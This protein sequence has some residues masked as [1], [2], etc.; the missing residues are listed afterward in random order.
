[1]WN[2]RSWV[3]PGTIPCWFWTKRSRNGHHLFS[4]LSFFEIS[5]RP[6]LQCYSIGT[7][8]TLLVGSICIPLDAFL[9]ASTWRLIM[10]ISLLRVDT[11]SR[12]FSPGFKNLIALTCCSLPW[13]ELFCSFVYF[14][15]FSSV[16]SS[17]FGCEEH[18]S[19]GRNGGKSVW[20][21]PFAGYLHRQCVREEDR[22]KN[23]CSFVSNS[24]SVFTSSDS[25]QTWNL[26]GIETCTSSE[27]G[28]HEISSVLQHVLLVKKANMKSVWY[29]NML[30]SVYFHCN[31]VSSAL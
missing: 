27:E 15:F 24:M 8:C 7:V 9:P 18:S 1:M 16:R 3:P 11:S 13:I 4:R 19:R 6:F 31:R 21:W 23:I 26:F 20:F 30:S 12:E 14:F 17:G 29:C 5:Q 28:K 22:G 10:W 25:R 2:F